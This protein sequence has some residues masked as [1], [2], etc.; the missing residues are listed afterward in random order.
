MSVGSGARWEVMGKPV[1]VRF[2][3]PQSAGNNRS[4]SPSLA[5]LVLCSCLKL[6][7]NV[8]PVTSVL[9]SGVVTEITF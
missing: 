9:P 5:A 7:L 4:R 1:K 2:Q 8:T 6:G 3:L